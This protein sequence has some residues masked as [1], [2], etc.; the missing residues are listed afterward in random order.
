MSCGTNSACWSLRVT[1]QRGSS[2]SVGSGVRSTGSARRWA[3]VG[4]VGAGFG[5]AR[6][7][8][9]LGGEVC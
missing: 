7:C 9:N 1:T 5:H 2:T 3:P 8:A 4:A 6:A